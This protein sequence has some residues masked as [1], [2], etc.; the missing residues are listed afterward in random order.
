M[1]I[2]KY[3]CQMCN[4]QVEVSAKITE[5]V[6]PPMCCHIVMQRDFTAPNIIFRGTGWGK[7]K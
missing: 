2:Y 3:K 4:A 1:P 5:D 7:D 6:W